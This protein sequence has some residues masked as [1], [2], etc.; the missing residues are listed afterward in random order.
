VVAG[1]TT[2]LLV[3]SA[4]VWSSVLEAV[5]G[6]TGFLLEEVLVDSDSQ[7]AQVGS[8]VVEV[9][10]GSTVFLV[11]VDDEVQS[12]QVCSSVEVVTA[13]G[14]LLVVVERD[15]TFLVVVEVVA[16][17]TGLE[18][19]PVLEP[20]LE[21]VVAGSTGL[22][23]HPVVVLPPSTGSTLVEFQSTQ[24]SR[25]TLLCNLACMF[26]TWLEAETDPITAAPA[27]AIVTAL[28]LMMFFPMIY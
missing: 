7:S 16:G 4:Q 20:V 21:E 11:V 22:E 10:A 15:G 1:S 24:L 13:P 25:A 26:S 3:Q 5:A 14:T 19:H 8:S 6:S 12:S 2:L 27:A 18:P 23:P 28:M 9:V 17:S